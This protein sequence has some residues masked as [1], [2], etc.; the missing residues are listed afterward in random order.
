MGKEAVR[1]QLHVFLDDVTQFALED[2]RPLAVIGLG[3][4][5]GNSIVKLL[6]SPFISKE[7][8]V[9]KITLQNE[10]NVILDL[11]EAMNEGDPEPEDYYDRFMQHD[12]F[13]QNYHGPHEDEFRD[14]LENRLE[15]VAEDLAPLLDAESD[16]FWGALVETHDRGEAKDMLTYHFS[17]TEK[18]VTRFGD[19]LKLKFK[20]MPLLVFDYTDEAVRVLPEAEGY[21]REQ[22]LETIDEEYRKRAI[23]QKEQLEEENQELR[24]R[25]EELETRNQELEDKLNSVK[26]KMQ[27]HRESEG[28]SDGAE[29]Q[30]TDEGAATGGGAGQGDES[31]DSGI[32]RGDE[33]QT[34]GGSD[35]DLS[36]DGEG[37]IPLDVEK[38]E[39]EF[40]IEAEDS[41]DD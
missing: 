34:L 27:E 22:M 41:E 18:V 9:I 14:L 4:L 15:E 7:L 33:A 26:Q 16:D 39:D 32:S 36:G 29:G 20:L 37:E 30:R 6:M 10:F 1:N 24:R 13:Y 8:N 21:L 2:F 38:A 5:P 3:F 31:G 28:P 19:G 11:A 23:Q 40:G 12:F 17:F 25:V 35:D